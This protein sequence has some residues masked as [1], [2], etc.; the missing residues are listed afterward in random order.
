MT[1]GPK[2]T[3][4]LNTLKQ[5]QTDLQTASSYAAGAASTMLNSDGSAE[6]Q[7]LC[8]EVVDACAK[9]LSDLAV[10]IGVLQAAANE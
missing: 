8:Q 1:L 9:P 6:A 2:S 5:L 7:A 10:A 4:V 3:D